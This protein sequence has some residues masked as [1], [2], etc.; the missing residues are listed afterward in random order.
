MALWHGAASETVHRVPKQNKVSGRYCV[1]DLATCCLYRSVS[2]STLSPGSASVWSLT[3]CTWVLHRLQPSVHNWKQ[4]A[5][6]RRESWALTTANRLLSHCPSHH[7]FSFSLTHCLNKGQQPQGGVQGGRGWRGGCLKRWELNFKMAICKRQ[8]QVRKYENL[9]KV[10]KHV[11]KAVWAPRMK[12]KQEGDKV[13]AGCDEWD[14]SCGANTTFFF[15]FSFILFFFLSFF[16]FLQQNCLEVFHRSKTMYTKMNAYR[17]RE[18]E[19][20]REGGS[21]RKRERERERE[22]EQEE[23]RGSSSTMLPAALQQKSTQHTIATTQ[24]PAL[25]TADP[26]TEGEEW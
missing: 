12:K 17:E 4:L 19:R 14:G 21:K 26:C 9:Q 22:R 2:A 13:F 1:S 20:E 16:F 5:F 8:Q 23:D 25:H 7:P 24:P 15:L 11:D 18:R 6:L 3:H 10:I